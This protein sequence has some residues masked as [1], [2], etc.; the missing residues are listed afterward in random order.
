MPYLCAALGQSAGFNERKPLDS[1][2]DPSD[3]QGGGQA[4]RVILLRT[5]K[6]KSMK[7]LLGALLALGLLGAV[8]PAL[9]QTYEHSRGAFSSGGGR[10]VGGVFSISGSV[11][12]PMA[13]AASG[14]YF[15]L[16]SGFW[17]S[18]GLP[19]G[20]CGDVDGNGVVNISDSIRIL[21]AVVRLQPLTPS[22]KIRADVRRDNVIDIADSIRLLRIIVRAEPPCGF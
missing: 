22:E 17:S 5:T 6:G 4:P 2:C 21:R 14:G 19:L 15:A 18:G 13:G 8:P 10:S 16:N 1:G 12:Q 3:T 7:I 20:V 9:A 11:G